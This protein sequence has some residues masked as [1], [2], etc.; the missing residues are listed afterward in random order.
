MQSDS[1]QQ[2]GGYPVFCIECH[3]YDYMP[4]GHKSWVCSRCK[5]LQGLRERV[6]SLEAL[7]ADLEKRRQAEE[8]RGETSG[9]DQASS[10]PQAC[11]SSA[12]RVG[13]L[14]TGGRHPGEE[15]NNPLGGTP[16]PGDGPVSEWIVGTLAPRTL[17]FSSRNMTE[18][19]CLCL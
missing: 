10:Q 15:G 14:G 6:R 12:A 11:S 5:E 2:G 3:M 4:L 1:Q 18:S 7:V 17:L 8:D 16:S 9:D 19:N 13:S